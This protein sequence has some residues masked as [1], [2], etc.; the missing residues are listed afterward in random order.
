MCVCVGWM[1][2]CVCVSVATNDQIV[3]PYY[4][5]TGDWLYGMID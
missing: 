5:M 2:M 1:P 3:E 4:N